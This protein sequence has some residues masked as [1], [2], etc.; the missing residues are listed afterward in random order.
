MQFSIVLTIL[1]S[2][3]AAAGP[4]P[5][6]SSAMSLN[7]REALELGISIAKR[8]LG[9]TVCDGAVC[10]DCFLFTLRNKRS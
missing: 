9:T 6:M 7:E 2:A 8:S 4:I 3:F 5:G 10:L 1:L